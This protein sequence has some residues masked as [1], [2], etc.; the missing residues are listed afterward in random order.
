MK[1]EIILLYRYFLWLCGKLPYQ[2]IRIYKTFLGR[3]EVPNSSN[4][5]KR[6]T[7]DLAD[8]VCDFIED[9]YSMSRI[10]KDQR[11]NWYAALGKYLPDLRQH[12]VPKKQEVFEEY[13]ELHKQ[14]VARNGYG[15]TSMVTQLRNSI[16]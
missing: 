16:K 8:H 15:A 4:K 14:N 5:D 11:N 7:S 1:D 6:F 2:P 13:I 9:A 10:T 12:V 3:S